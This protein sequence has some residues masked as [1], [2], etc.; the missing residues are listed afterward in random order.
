LSSEA[1]AT[2]TSLTPK[3]KYQLTFD[4]MYV[5]FGKVRRGQKRE[6][7]FHFQNTGTDPVVV[8]IVTSCDCT[9]L[10]WPEGKKIMPGTRD[11]IH[12]V[13][14]ST[15]KEAS[16]TVDIDVILQ[17]RDEKDRPI[18]YILQYKFELLQ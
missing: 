2:F 4:T 7:T 5:D 13:F 10:T 1:V 14:D 12:A 17:Q 16:E 6:Y 9:T 8:D 3:P 11:Q 15:E 18:L